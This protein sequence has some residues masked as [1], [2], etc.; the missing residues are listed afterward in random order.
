M[1]ALTGEAPTTPSQTALYRA[2]GKSTR[3]VVGRGPKL[4]DSGLGGASR[5]V[6]RPHER[7]S[8]WAA[9]GVLREKGRGRFGSG[10][11]P[12]LLIALTGEAPQAPQ[13]GDKAVPLHPLANG[14]VPSSGRVASCGRGPRSHAAGFDFGC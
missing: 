1:I 3:A 11:H 7:D 12:H 8:A 4:L 5:G 2:A 6:L 10:G 13:Q 14:P 9:V